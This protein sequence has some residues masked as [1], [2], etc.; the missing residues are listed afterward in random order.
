ME[1]GCRHATATCTP[2]R[3]VHRHVLSPRCCSNRSRAQACQWFRLANVPTGFRPESSLSINRPSV[4]L[5][6]QRPPHTSH[7]PRKSRLNEFR[8]PPSTRACEIA[9]FSQRGRTKQTR[10]AG[11]GGDS[12]LTVVTGLLSRAP[13]QQSWFFGLAL[14]QLRFYA[15]TQLRIQ[16]HDC[17]MF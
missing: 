13:P 12:R 17:H 6:K 1:S 5:E 7:G 3:L 4:S 16:M 15:L 10:I 11:I 8:S 9:R 2:Q 14:T